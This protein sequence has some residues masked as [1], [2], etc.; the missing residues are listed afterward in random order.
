MFSPIWVISVEL[1]S[2]RLTKAD[3]M[4]GWNKCPPER[5]VYTSASRHGRQVLDKYAHDS[6]HGAMTHSKTSQTNYMSLCKYT[7]G[8]V[9][10]QRQTTSQN[11]ACEL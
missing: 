11:V 1:L 8:Q 4:K 7:K 6:L 3:I 5:G 9:C 10:V 2:K